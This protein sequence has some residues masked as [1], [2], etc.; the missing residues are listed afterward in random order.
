VAHGA[1]PP[2][3]AACADRSLAARG[4]TEACGF[5]LVPPVADAKLV[6]LTRLP[7]TPDAACEAAEVFFGALGLLTEWVADSPGLVLGRVVAQLVNEAAFAIGEGVGTA[8]DVDAGLMLGFNH[9]R[10]PVGWSEAIGLEHVLATIDGLYEER[11][12]ERYRAAPLLRSR[13]LLGAGLRD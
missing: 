3:L 13:A 6:E 7:A 10:G 9:P 11:R 1:L 2:A 4:V 5:N 8:D 12:E